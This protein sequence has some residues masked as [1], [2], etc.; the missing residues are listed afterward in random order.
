MPSL[1]IE[2]RTSPRDPQV[3]ERSIVERHRVL[4]RR[5]PALAS[6]YAPWFDSVLVDI[7]RH[8]R[9]LEVG[10]GPGFF[11]AY[12]RRVRPDLR[13]HTSDYLVVP[14]NDLVAD[15]V[16]LPIR[17]ASVGAV[18]GCDILH[19][20]A[21]PGHFLAEAARILQPQGSLLLLE[22][23]LTCLSYPVYRF[24]HHEECRPAVD[25]W[26]PFEADE[27]R[28]KQAFEGNAAVPWSMLRSASSD[29]WA[30][31]G[32]EPPEIELYNGFTYLLSLGLRRPH[33][34]PGR[35]ATRALLRFD[36]WSQPTARWFAL[37]ARIRWPKP[38]AR[39][40]PDHP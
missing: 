21:R 9:V 14:G 18:V 16:Q 28:G 19:H 11:S 38:A 23:W 35:A 6:I 37:R 2:Q 27:T 32:L 4:W 8:A 17:D 33:L 30:A 31:M 5:K 40:E 25:P 29:D 1:T 15:A 10:A 13:W 34:L 12:A 24:A 36:R 20:L 3:D 22:P 39:H 7:P 26:Q